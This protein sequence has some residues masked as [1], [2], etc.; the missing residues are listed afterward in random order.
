MGN[1]PALAVEARSMTFVSYAQNFE[2]VLLWRALHSVERGFYIDAGA[3]H[4]DTD[5]VT[6]AFHDR[7]WH[8]INVEPSAE[9]FQ[10]LEAARPRLI[11]AV[12]RAHLAHPY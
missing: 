3:W 2:D 4:P 9:G 10:R 11:E 1:P 12:V 6:R 7:G 5:S 8:G